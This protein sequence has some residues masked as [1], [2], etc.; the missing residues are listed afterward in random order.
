MQD[1]ISISHARQNNLKD[2]SIKIPHNKFTVITGISGSG[3]SSLVYDVL[4]AEG[5]RRLIDA[6]PKKVK[7]NIR[8]M[9][10]PD[11]ESITGLKPM[12]S[13]SQNNLSTSDIR[14]TV[15]S[16][17][18]IEHY[19]KAI[20]SQIGEAHCPCC[21]EKVKIMSADEVVSVLLS[22]EEG[23]KIDII[24]HCSRHTGESTLRFISRINGDII[25]IDGQEY[26]LADYEVTDEIKELFFKVDCVEVR[27]SNRQLLL[28]AFNKASKSGTGYISIKVHGSKETERVLEESCC[29]KH[30][31]FRDIVKYNQLSSGDEQ[32]ACYYC[33]GI[34][35]TK[36]AHPAFTIKDP[37][38][39]LVK[40]A[41]YNLMY[42]Q[43]NPGSYNGRMLRSVINKY[44]I[45]PEKPFEELPEEHKNIILFGSDEPIPLIDS[46]EGKETF[47]FHGYTAFLNAFYKEH[48]IWN[49]AGVIKTHDEL[50]KNTMVMKT[51]PICHGHKLNPQ[52]RTITYKG[53]SVSDLCLMTFDEL[54]EFFLEVE[55][56]SDN[57]PIIKPALSEIQKRISLLIELGLSYLNCYIEIDS[58]SSGELQRL[59]LAKCLCSEMDD[60]IY[61]LDEP[62]K[63]LHAADVGNIVKIIKDVCASGNTV[64]AV[65]HNPEIIKQADYI[66]EMG[67]YSGIN[68]GNITAGGSFSEIMNDKNFL[69]GKYI[70]DGIACG[71]SGLSRRIG[72][73][74][75][76]LGIRN[77][78]EN[79]L[80]NVDVDIPLSCIVCV[81]GVSGSGKSS[82]IHDVL[83][84]TLA[85]EKMGER[86]TPGE[87]DEIIN[88]DLIDN[89]YYIDQKSLQ[90]NARS[91]VYTYMNISQEIAAAMAKL[92]QSRELELSKKD[93]M[94]H[95]SSSGRCFYCE[96]IGYIRNEDT[97]SHNLPTVCP[98]CDGMQYSQDILSIY[99]NG[100]NIYEIKNMSVSEAVEFYKDNKKIL[101]KLNCLIA[102]NLGYLKL[103]QST[104][105]LS[106]GEKQRLKMAYTMSQLKSGERNLF[107]LDEPSTGLHLH[108]LSCL[109]DSFNYLV[110]HGNSIIFIEHNLKLIEC[111][112]YIIDIGPGSGKN[113]GKIIS[114]GTLHEIMGNEKSLTGR[115]LR[116][117]NMSSTKY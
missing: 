14:T 51:C 3:K 16:V 8:H 21:G 111:A 77:A 76:A 99:M 106:G 65:E 93:F 54:S 4:Y 58:I 80:K 52:A 44:N 109:V 95:E 86:V 70:K 43:S 116:N 62:S 59:Q 55:A 9:V 97:F 104:D 33:S 66:V 37:K 81:T 18:E 73:I 40:G 39:G 50:M 25:Y 45:D 57:Y 29:S 98:V 107:I 6:F 117:R 1:F 7:E 87:H 71:S 10:N 100:K 101:R 69:T 31:V 60:T 2:V 64:I 38:K 12:F 79:N 20:I 36:E 24:A 56:E 72:N 96:G 92:P 94:I 75:S 13:L 23:Y 35:Y 27:K 42:N 28:D 114:C 103:G 49:K 53:K 84:N 102:M 88:K 113:G 78:R 85:A 63:Y 22:V 61:I 68:G 15:G 83:Y 89:V 82:L 110:K 74:D 11:V 108:D 34:G 46:K 90:K 41:L 105:T 115:F 17:S 26:R 91:Y 30:H 19:I 32:G 112:D 48:Y 67:P 5:Y 47:I